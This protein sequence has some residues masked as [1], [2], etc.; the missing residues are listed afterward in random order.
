MKGNPQLKTWMATSLMGVLGFVLMLIQFPVP[1]IPFLK[2]DLGE[3][4]I[5]IVGYV[6]GFELGVVALLIKSLLF[7]LARFSMVE[8]LGVGINVV[9]TTVF[10]RSMLW[11]YEQKKTRTRAVL[12]LVVASLLTTVIL[13][14]LNYFLYPWFERW[15]LDTD[16]AQDPVAFGKFILWVIV[17]FNLVKWPLTSLIVFLTY[18]RVAVFLRERWLTKF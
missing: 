11:I 7:L 1:W 3:I 15:Y 8:L 2:L 14:L 10:L 4:P 12:S 5:L 13:S 18:K 6:L 9:G 16:L 17:P